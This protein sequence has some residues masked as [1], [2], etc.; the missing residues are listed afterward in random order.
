MS[1]VWQYVFFAA[2]LYCALQAVSDFRRKNYGMAVA[3]AAL[4]LA[5]IL[6]PGL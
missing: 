4:A 5:L 2:E 3:G 6:R 1:T